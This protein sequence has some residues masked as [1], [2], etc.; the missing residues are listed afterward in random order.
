MFVKL[1]IVSGKIIF[2]GASVSFLYQ[3]RKI[4]FDDESGE[5]PK[6]TT[7]GEMSNKISSKRKDSV[8]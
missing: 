5:Y 1:V 8:A 2:S 3:P 6:L 4:A 7:D